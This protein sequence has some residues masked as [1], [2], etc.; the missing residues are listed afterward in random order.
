VLERLWRIFGKNYKNK[1]SVVSEFAMSVY[2]PSDDLV[3][4]DVVAP[5]ISRNF[6]KGRGRIFLYGGEILGG[7]WDFFLETLANRNNF[8][9]RGNGV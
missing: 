8:P 4:V 2:V 3:K 9:K 7:F 5:C 6:S 1:N